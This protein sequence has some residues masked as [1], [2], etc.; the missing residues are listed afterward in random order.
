MP[1]NRKYNY[2]GWDL[3]HEIIYTLAVKVYVDGIDGT[4]ATVAESC[5]TVAFITTVAE[6]CHTVGI[7]TTVAVTCHTI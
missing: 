7:T 1:H 6:V 5:H 3:P 4:S 2:D